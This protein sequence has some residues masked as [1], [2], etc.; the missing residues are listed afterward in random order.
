MTADNFDT[1]RT[2]NTLKGIAIFTV[3]INHYLNLN[4]LKD[5]SGFASAW[6]SIFFIMSGYGVYHS[7]SIRSSGDAGLKKIWGSF[8]RDRA[9]RI[10]PLLWIAWIIQLAINK[11]GMSGWTI[12]GIHAQGHY[13]FISAILECYAI[14]PLLYYGTK[15][16]KWTMI[17]GVSIAVAAINFWIRLGYPSQWL[18]TAMRFPHIPYRTV[19]L[20][21]I[22]LF[23][24]GMIMPY[25]FSH[26][27]AFHRRWHTLLF[28]VSGIAILCFMLVLKFL[29]LN[30]LLFRL[31]PIPIIA[32]FC[33]FALQYQMHNS[34]CEYL[35]RLS[36]PIY[37]FHIS[38]YILMGR[39]THFTKNSLIT[40]MVYI[41][42]SRYLYIYA[43][44]LKSLAAISAGS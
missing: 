3:L 35:G 39:I 7:L 21:N 5:S 43:K 33:V 4:T 13:W 34:F 2:T 30:D 37:L 6:I 32:L 24:F 42:F 29:V 8:Y 14:A 26:A 18:T 40:L 31:A 16:S 36:Y 27:H 28:W 41:A 22:V 25:M 19:Y 20:L 11:G 1:T 23:L 15:K 9:I 12:I 17:A 10:F 38:F 44:N